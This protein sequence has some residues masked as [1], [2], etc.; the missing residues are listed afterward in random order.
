MGMLV[1]V[2]G[3]WVCAVM[4]V[5]H[6]TEYYGKDALSV[7]Y[8][9]AVTSIDPC[10]RGDID[11]YAACLSSPPQ[12]VLELGCGTGRVSIAL[13][14]RGH[15]VVGV[16]NSESMLLR[17]QLKRRGMTRAQQRNIQLLTYDILSLN[18]PAQF[19]LVLL[20]FYTLNHIEGRRLRARALLTISR[21]LLPGGK[22]IIHAASPQVLCEQRTPRKPGHVFEF[23]D[24]GGRLEVTWS[25]RIVDER[26]QKSTTIVEYELFAADGRLLSASVAHLK[27][28]W[29]SDLELKNSARKADLEIEQTLTSFGSE[30]GRERIYILRKSDAG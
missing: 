5:N 10:V 9:D 27:Y 3:K 21:H 26:Q 1:I 6:K 19:H 4:R 7:R 30:P 8:Y 14:A 17:A 18:L 29:F 20:P 25:K 11:F 28:W 13:A 24:S 2:V 15:F 16:D 12:R 22:A 23:E